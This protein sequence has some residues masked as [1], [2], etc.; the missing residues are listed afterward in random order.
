MII[1]RVFLA[2]LIPFESGKKSDNSDFLEKLSLFSLVQQFSF[3]DAFVIEVCW[4]CCT[5]SPASFSQGSSFGKSKSCHW[6]VW[7]YHHYF[8]VRL[9]SWHAL[10]SPFPEFTNIRNCTKLWVYVSSLS[11]CLNVTVYVYISLDK[12]DRV[13]NNYWV[14]PSFMDDIISYVTRRSCKSKRS[15]PILPTQVARLCW[16]D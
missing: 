3:D 5:L 2:L 15:L 9:K 11:K 13:K 12:S 4:N 14:R 6:H 10:V 16:K 8:M 1:K 7:I